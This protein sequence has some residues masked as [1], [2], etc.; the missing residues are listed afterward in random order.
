MS[1]N[2]SVLLPVDIA[3]KI[4]G[5]SERSLVKLLAYDR[6]FPRP[7]RDYAGR[8]NWR[9]TELAAWVELRRVQ[10]LSQRKANRAKARSKEA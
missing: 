7:V 1:V 2:P 5:L 6:A 8:L 3:A 10:R 4:A 9:A